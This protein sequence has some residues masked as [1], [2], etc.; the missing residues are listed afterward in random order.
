MYSYRTLCRQ[1]DYVEQSSYDVQVEDLLTYAH[2]T[3]DVALIVNPQVPPLYVRAAS[4]ELDC[5]ANHEDLVAPDPLEERSSVESVHEAVLA[6]ARE[7]AENV[8]SS[9]HTSPTSQQIAAL[10]PTSDPHPREQRAAD[11]HELRSLL[12]VLEERACRRHAQKSWEKAS[13]E[14]GEQDKVEEAR[15]EEDQQEEVH[16]RRKRRGGKGNAAWKNQ[17]RQ[18]KEDNERNPEAGPSGLR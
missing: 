11:L 4:I 5:C 18:E 3:P 9:D 10:D 7:N 15:M 1:F 14:V 8:T 2:R 6:N 13:T 16:Q 12:P 17:R